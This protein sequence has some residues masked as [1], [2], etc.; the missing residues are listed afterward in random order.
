LAV[1]LTA[2]DPSATVT[3]AGKL[4]AALSL[5]RLTANPPLVAA[6][7]SATVQMSLVGPV[8]LASTQLSELNSGGF[9]AATAAPVPLN[10]TTSAPFAAAPL[11]IVSSPVAIPVAD[12]EKLTLKLSVCP[13]ATVMGKS[14]EPLTVNDCPARLTCETCTA[15][16]PGFT[17]ETLA[18]V[19]VPSGTLPK[20][21]LVGEAWSDPALAFAFVPIICPPTH[22]LS[23][24]G[25][26]QANK[27][28]LYETKNERS[29]P[30]PATRTGECVPR[31]LCRGAPSQSAR[32][33]AIASSNVTQEK[34]SRNS[35]TGEDPYCLYFLSA[36]LYPLVT[37]RS[38]GAG[39]QAHLAPAA[40]NTQCRR[41]LH[42]C[43]SA[44]LLIRVSPRGTHS[45][46]IS[47]GGK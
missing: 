31:R 47:R 3:E 5:V 43:P 18:L 7:L 19:V 32:A 41:S 17:R 39:L 12:G 8:A 25:T 42:S 45:S 2:V 34:M 20:L 30:G 33:V 29:P 26:Q 14:P 6:V 46:F 9:G 22:P 13:A 24:K 4:T 21:T 1:K 36:A 27:T 40:R 35:I 37:Y 10:P 15:A 11:A 44:V 16:D 28:K 38:L 23:R